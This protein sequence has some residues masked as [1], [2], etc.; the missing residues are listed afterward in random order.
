MLLTNGM[1]QLARSIAAKRN[2]QQ[3]PTSRRTPPPGPGERRRTIYDGWWHRYS[4]DEMA[5]FDRMEQMTVRDW[6]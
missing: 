6:L 4:A 1:Q 3:A 5:A 2:P